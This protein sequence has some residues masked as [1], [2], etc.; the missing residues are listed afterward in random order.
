M[1]RFRVREI[2]DWFEGLDRVRQSSFRLILIG[3][4]SEEDRNRISNIF[5][6]YNDTVREILADK[7]SLVYDTDEGEIWERWNATQNNVFV[8]NRCGVIV[9]KSDVFGDATR[10]AFEV[11]YEN[12][13]DSES[14]DACQ[15]EVDDEDDEDEDEDDE[16][17]DN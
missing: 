8:L 11:A 1:S 10:E 3:K 5:H 15:C 14:E 17:D 4:G 9:N 16:D 12:E 6:S 2:R 7:W 13:D